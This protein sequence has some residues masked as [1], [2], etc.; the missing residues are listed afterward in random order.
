[1]SIKLNFLIMAV[2]FSMLWGLAILPFVVDYID[3]NPNV[4][5]VV[6]TILYYSGIYVSI[7]MF[8]YILV[9]ETP[10]LLK[11]S[12][13][14][15]LIYLLIDW[16][17]PPMI[18]SPSGDVAIGTPGYKASLDYAIGYYLQKDFNLT[19][20]QVYNTEVW[21]VPLVISLAIIFIATPQL[22]GRALRRI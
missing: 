19:W 21:L 7:M 10:E 20:K 16:W 17:E 9:E 14:L 5:P 2:L 4:E 22:L 15:F 11:I 8:T 12:V 3:K 6:A 18:I 1:M 13:I